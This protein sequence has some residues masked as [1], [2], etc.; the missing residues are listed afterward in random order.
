MLTNENNFD[1]PIE[2]YKNNKSY[3]EIVRRKY[4]ITDIGLLY[5]DK[6]LLLIYACDWFNIQP[7]K[8]YEK[9]CYHPYMTKRH[10]KKLNEIYENQKNNLFLF[11]L[12]FYGLLYIAKRKFV[13]GTNLRK[14]FT[15]T[16]LIFLSVVFFPILFWKFYLLKNMNK[17]IQIDKDLKQYLHLDIDRNKIK[18]DLLNYNIVL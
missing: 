1:K 16:S 10:H 8:V 7:T 18:E 9:V 5:D 13:K 11:S 14:N 6:I 2:I 15:A 17:D 3:Q 12:P 4:N